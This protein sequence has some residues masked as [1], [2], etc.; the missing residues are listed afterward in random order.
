MSVSPL[1]HKEQAGFANLETKLTESNAT[2]NSTLNESS[3]SSLQR[4]LVDYIPEVLRKSSNEQV[5][6]LALGCVIILGGLMILVGNCLLQHDSTASGASRDGWYASFSGKTQK[7]IAE[8]VN[9]PAS[10]CS[11]ESSPESRNKWSSEY[12]SESLAPNYSLTFRILGQDIVRDEVLCDYVLVMPLKGVS[13]ANL[14]WSGAHLTRLNWESQVDGLKLAHQVFK[15][16]NKFHLYTDEELAETFQTEMTFE[17]Y[18][19][20]MRNLLAKTFTG[21]RFGLVLGSDPSVDHDE[22]FVKLS[23]P[24]HNNTI[25]QYAG[26]L[27]YMMPLSDS[28][29][30]RVGKHIKQDADLNVTR[31]F[32][33]F[34]PE[35][36]DDFESFREIDIVRMLKARLDKHLNLTALCKQGLVVAHF[37]PHNYIEVQAMCE[38]WANVWQWYRI[39]THDND[40]RI[41]NYFGEEVAWMFVWNVHYVR[42]LCPP[43]MLGAFMYFRLVL[44]DPVLQ[45]EIQ[46][47]FAIIMALWSTLF[48]SFYDRREARTRYRWG[49]HNFTP[50]A[51]LF[52]RNEFDPALESMWRA[53]IVSM[54]GD[55]LGAMTMAGTVGGM[56]AIDRYFDASHWAHAF[57]ITAQIIIIDV[58]WRNMSQ[59]IV[60]FENHKHQDKWLRS[61]TRKMFCV[62]LFNN[63]YPFLYVAFL[64]EHYHNEGCRPFTSCLD[65]VNRDLLAFFAV[66]ILK[67]V[68]LNL[69]RLGV[70]RMQIFQ[71][72]WTTA[73]S[74]GRSETLRFNHT[75]LEL[76]SKALPYNEIVKMN[77][78]IEQV[79]TF[80]FVACFSVVL[81]AISF[82][83]L[84]AS[85]LRT[86][87]VA[88][89]NA[90]YLR[91]PLARGA[92]GIGA[93]REMLGFIEVIAVVINLG[94][95]IFLMKPLCDLSV[96]KKFVIFFIA[97]HFILAL[98]LGW[99]NKFPTLPSD[100]EKNDRACQRLV[101]RSFIDQKRHPVDAEIVC[102]DYP[103]IGPNAFGGRN[104]TMR[105][106]SEVSSTSRATM[107]RLLTEADLSEDPTIA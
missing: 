49:M 69:W 56:L 44:K 33:E 91:R 50:M 39:P 97:E 54:I 93:W 96:E 34:F 83:A 29:Y 46:V 7:Q 92:A 10:P 86:R 79:L 66:R 21:S 38:T 40:D 18:H 85:L 19:E 68:V 42:W 47:D 90:L 48:N 88:H 57:L 71:E 73:H 59:L 36:K 98:K 17:Q 55:I 51:T 12:S 74:P 3:N 11:P 2:F 89:R 58:W 43:A 84:M 20:V 37:S 9:T 32:T 60:H 78:W 45:H 103:S 102:D 13:R 81:P 16:S 75:Y 107:R 26:N 61:W 8:E 53:L 64:K 5:N 27:S 4:F 70:M 101:R 30:D 87:L 1:I 94:F 25:G 15:S 35:H 82:I 23:V 6:S 104:S 99:K 95:A 62:R 22:I 77:D 31:A 105:R 52:A 63:L 14:H 100:V 72:S 80:A 106:A 41:R 65:E 76:Q 28:T 67:E 24:R